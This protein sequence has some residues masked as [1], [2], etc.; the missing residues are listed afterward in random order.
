[1]AGRAPSCGPGHGHHQD[2]SPA[3][4]AFRPLSFL[5]C[6]LRGP[7]NSS[8]YSKGDQKG[9]QGLQMFAK[10]TWGVGYGLWLQLKAATWKEMDKLSQWLHG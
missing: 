8:T 9:L 4:T 6:H 7:G 1:M 5:I 10:G 3:A 2:T